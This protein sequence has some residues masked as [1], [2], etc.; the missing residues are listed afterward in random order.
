MFPLHFA[1]LFL[2]LNESICQVKKNVFYFTSKPLFVLR[3]SNF[4][5]LHFQISWCHPVPKH[6]TYI[7]LNYLG[8]KHSLLMKFGQFMSYY[9]REDFFLL[10]LQRIKHS[11]YWKMKFLKQATYIRYVIAK[12]SKFVQISMLI[13]SDSF[14][15]RIL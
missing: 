9:K 1:N 10:C 5:I 12:L 2:G 4:R 13:S 7:S 14:L 3:K 6:K 8:S 15:Q 11:F